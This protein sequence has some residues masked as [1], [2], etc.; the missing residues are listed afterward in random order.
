MATPE[1]RKKE[2]LDKLKAEDFQ[3]RHRMRT[4]GMSVIEFECR[5]ERLDLDTEDTIRAA[6]DKKPVCL[7]AYQYENFCYRQEY[8]TYC[9]AWKYI[10]GAE[11]ALQAERQSYWSFFWRVEESKENLEELANAARHGCVFKM[12]IMEELMARTW[13]PDR[14]IAWCLDVE[15]RREWVC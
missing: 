8:C 6:R 11:A 14:F 1:E 13:H 10:H 12:Q 15:E 5:M 7:N 2:L 3:I 9:K 4:T